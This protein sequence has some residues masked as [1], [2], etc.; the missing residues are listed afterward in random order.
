MKKEFFNLVNI[1][2]IYLGVSNCVIMRQH[3][4]NLAQDWLQRKNS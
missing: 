1:V 2:L 3:I 4:T